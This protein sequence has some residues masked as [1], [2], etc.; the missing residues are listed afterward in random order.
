MPAAKSLRRALGARP[1]A[2]VAR[3][4]TKGNV[5]GPTAALCGP[6]LLTQVTTEP[7]N[8]LSRKYAERSCRSVKYSAL[9]PAVGKHAVAITWAG[10][11][12][13]RSCAVCHAVCRRRPHTHDRHQAGLPGDALSASHH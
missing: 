8:V 10:S 1:R 13:Q 9:S 7:A 6:R 5:S 2:E 4:L 3:S 11:S 12:E